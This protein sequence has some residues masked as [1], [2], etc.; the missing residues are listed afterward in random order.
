MAEYV[1]LLHGIFR[2]ARSMRQL[3]RYLTRHGYAVL[4]FTYPSTRHTLAELAAKLH[5]RLTPYAG[6]KLHFVGHSMGGL[7]IREYLNAYP[8]AHPGRVV[9]LGTPN[10]GSEIADAIGDW[11]LFNALYG[12][13]GQQLR[14]SEAQRPAPL[15]AEVG[16]I[17]GDLSLDPLFGWHLPRP[18][19]GKVSV[20]STKLKEMRDHLQL[21][22][23][24]SLMPYDGQVA[25]QVLYF[26]NEGQFA[27]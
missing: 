1:V 10:H 19:D 20:D 24:H 18:H 11:W 12:P 16:I 7:L 14:T 26:L 9:M 21:R 17:A 27:R 22:V 13:A 25:R 4:N 8:P 3:E 6:A 2:T 23:A 5:E 15:R